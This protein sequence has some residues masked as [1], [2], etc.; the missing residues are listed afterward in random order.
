MLCMQDVMLLV[1]PY[2][3][4]VKYDL[5]EQV[6]LIQEVDGEICMPLLQCIFNVGEWQRSSCFACPFMSRKPNCMQIARLVHY[7]QMGFVRSTDMAG[8]SH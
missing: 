8:G 3:D 6:I 4:W 1:G 7:M 5:E 2:G